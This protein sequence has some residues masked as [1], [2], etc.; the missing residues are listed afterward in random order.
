MLYYNETNEYGPVCVRSRKPAVLLTSRT[1]FNL[2]IH[3]ASISFVL[4]RI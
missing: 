2:K 3:N 4:A 1:I